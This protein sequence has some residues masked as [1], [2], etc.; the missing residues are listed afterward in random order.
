MIS[1][2]CSKKRGS[3][4]NG[5]GRKAGRGAG[6][7]GGTGNAGL[8]K[9]K[10]MQINKHTFFGRPGF[11]RPTES[12]QQRYVPLT[13]EELNT[14]IKVS[15][16]EPVEDRVINLDDLLKFPSKIL[17]TGKIMFKGPL[18]IVCSFATAKAI[19]KLK[20]REITVNLNEK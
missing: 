20:L 7:R 19:S 8:G 18:E 1:N 10:K 5:R 6:K 14:I 4:T 3:R 17:G 2:S 12:I 9:H 16:G 13:L 11:T 15:T